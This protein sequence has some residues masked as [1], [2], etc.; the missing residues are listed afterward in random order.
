MPTSYQRDDARR[1]IDVTVEGD[2]SAREALDIVSRQLADGAWSYSIL[3]DARN[4]TSQPSTA[5]VRAMV[6]YVGRCIAQYGPR[7]PVA[8]VTRAPSNYGMARMY[9]TL[10]EPV[11]LTVEV[12]REIEEAEAWLVS[13]R[14]PL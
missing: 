6:E 3:Y 1:R 8:I 2:V 4:D 11:K 12:F 7:G 5:D 10:G 14:P 9:S 13:Q